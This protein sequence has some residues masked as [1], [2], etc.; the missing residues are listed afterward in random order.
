MVRGTAV[1]APG[2]HVVS[3]RNA[4][5][6]VHYETTYRGCPPTLVPS[7]FLL[8]DALPLT[9]NSGSSS[10]THCTPAS[11]RNWKK[12]SSSQHPIRSCAGES[13]LVPLAS[14]SRH[15]RQLLWLDTDTPAGYSGDF[16]SGKSVSG[17]VTAAPACLKHPVFS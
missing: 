4:I 17:R 8:I 7:A 10:L 9:T 6:S 14:S 1:T 5:W 11:T 3:Y 13:G 16:P 15:P 12:P 2:K